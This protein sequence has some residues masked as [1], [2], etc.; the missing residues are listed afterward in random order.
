MIPLL[1]ATLV[2]TATLPSP[3]VD[4]TCASAPLH[5]ATDNVPIGNGIPTSVVNIWWFSEGTSQ[6]VAWL[7]RNAVGHYYMQ[8]N[9]RVDAARYKD[10]PMS[11]TLLRASN[12]YYP[13]VRLDGEQIV[14]IESALLVQGV[15]RG[16]CFSADYKM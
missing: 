14:R 10:L 13:I 1:L 3:T 4:A 9:G 5:I 12:G 8:F 16:A 6:P 15:A 7:Y 11:S 2:A